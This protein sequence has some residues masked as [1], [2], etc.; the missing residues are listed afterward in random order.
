MDGDQTPEQVAARLMPHLRRP[1]LRLC[2]SLWASALDAPGGT[3]F[4]GLPKLPPELDWPTAPAAGE[5]SAL[6]F[7][8]Q[9]D[10]SDV[11]KCDVGALLPSAGMLFF[12]YGIPDEDDLDDDARLPCAVLFHPTSTRESPPRQA[13]ARRRLR[14]QAFSV[15]L[16]MPETDPRQSGGFRFDA[17]VVSANSF[18]DDLRE[19]DHV[20]QASRTIRYR[21]SLDGVAEVCA[22]LAAQETRAFL[23]SRFPLPPLELPERNEGNHWLGPEGS[24]GVFCWGAMAS[25][26]EGIRANDYWGR[27]A[28]MS[29]RLAA[30]CKV[31]LERCALE[32]PFEAPSQAV[33][34]DFASWLLAGASDRS[35]GDL[36]SRFFEWRQVVRY[37]SHV[38]AEQ[39]ILDRINPKT[40]A[41]SRYWCEPR[42]E[43]MDTE[44]RPHEMFGHGASDHVVLT[45]DNLVP[46]Y[47]ALL[48]LTHLDHIMFDPQGEGAIQFWIK[49]IDLQRRDFAKV[50]CAY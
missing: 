3:Y 41:W 26:V 11:P 20:W 42:Y 34:E 10:L 23:S 37:W 16:W 36:Q 27:P 33:Q 6:L 25:L 47:I 40:L 35:L 7:G 15:P 5:D 12:F 48:T 38:F 45:P 29:D 24:R 43:I 46:D 21:G 39:R 8:F 9:L 1:C 18:P 31:W 2:R 22:D 17:V 19:G 32:D 14:R 50:V 44:Y 28:Q 30:E 4:G 13:P 49:P